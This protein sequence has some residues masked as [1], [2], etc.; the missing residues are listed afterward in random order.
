MARLAFITLSA[1]TMWLARSHKDNMAVRWL[2]WPPPGRLPTSVANGEIIWWR[3]RI[4][5]VLFS[6]CL[7][8]RRKILHGFWKSENAA[9]HIIYDSVPS[10]L[11]REDKTNSS[12]QTR[13]DH[14]ICLAATQPGC[15][16][17]SGCGTAS[18]F[19]LKGAFWEKAELTMAA[20][21]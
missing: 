18:F 7:N 13:N 21:V 3:R 1:C 5:G 2:S 10:V 9:R 14:C 20:L 11:E 8:A 6:Q 4:W 15:I 19:P 16:F 12:H 17:I